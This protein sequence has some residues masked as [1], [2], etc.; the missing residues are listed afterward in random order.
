MILTCNECGKPSSDGFNTTRYGYMCLSCA[1][2]LVFGSGKDGTTNPTDAGVGVT[3]EVGPERAT[4]PVRPVPANRT[5]DH[6]GIPPVVASAPAVLRRVFF[7]CHVCDRF[8]APWQGAL[9][10]ECFDHQEELMLQ[11]DAEL[12]GYRS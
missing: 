8:Q 9:C 10:Q 3:R 4:S 7:R 1:G 2:D 12:R 5:Q 6:S 11:R